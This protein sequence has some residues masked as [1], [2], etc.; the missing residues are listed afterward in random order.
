MQ[1]LTKHSKLV[2]NQPIGQRYYVSNNITDSHR[3]KTNRFAEICLIIAIWIQ[4]QSAIIL[5]GMGIA[6]AG[7]AGRYIL[8]RLPNLTE[9]VAEAMK[10]LPTSE[11]MATSKYYKGGF[12]PKMNKREASLIL[13]VSPTASKGKVRRVY[14]ETFGHSIYV[15]L[16]SFT[17]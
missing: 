15:S 2:G 3:N 4:F 12:D 5:A 11:S 17:D 16:V 7:F 10:N 8:R 1:A 9:Q 13:G 14:F 6:A